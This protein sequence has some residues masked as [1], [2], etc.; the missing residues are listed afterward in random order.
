MMLLQV[1]VTKQFIMQMNLDNNLLHPLITFHIPSLP[2]KF[3]YIHIYIYTVFQKD[4]FLYS[5]LIEVYSIIYLC[6][7][8]LV[9]GVC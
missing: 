8:S 6:L 4:I 1:M 5:K 3:I 7:F 2:S 9:P